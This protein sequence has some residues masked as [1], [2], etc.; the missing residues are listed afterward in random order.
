MSAKL[1]LILPLLIIAILFAG[2]TCTMN[3]QQEKV[4]SK[5]TIKLIKVDSTWIV[6]VDSIDDRGNLPDTTKAR[7][8][9]KTMITWE[10]VGTD[11]YFQFPDE[12]FDEHAP[13]TNKLSDNYT[14][15]IKDGGKLKLKI[16][17]DNSLVGNTYVYSVFCMQDS[18]YARG[19]SPPKIIV[20]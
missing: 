3:Q 13:G 18:T 2:Y 1:K 12:I 20:N 10:V 4:V 9:K 14:V 8:N 16:K 11:A 15:L 7:V 17:D 6:R 19:D 5:I